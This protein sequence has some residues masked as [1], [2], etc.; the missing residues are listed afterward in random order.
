MAIPL[1]QASTAGLTLRIEA[2]CANSAYY[3]EAFLK[4]ITANLDAQPVVRAHRRHQRN[5]EFRVR[6]PPVIRSAELEMFRRGKKMARL[7]L[8]ASCIEK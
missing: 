5:P 7:P 8:E 3:S 2:V 6:G 4:F 1:L